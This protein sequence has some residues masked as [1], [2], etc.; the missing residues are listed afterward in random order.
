M[1]IQVKFHGG[2]SPVEI[3]L[4]DP[5]LNIDG[6]IFGSVYTNIV[7]LES[8]LNLEKDGIVYMKNSEEARKI[9]LLFKSILDGENFKALK[10]LN[11]SQMIKNNKIFNTRE[12]ST[13]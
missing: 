4:K 5:D 1:G 7:I 8:L 11:L 3:I 12:Q 10:Q 6:S 13:K 2:K 9:V